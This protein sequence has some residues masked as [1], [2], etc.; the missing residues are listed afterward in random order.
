MEA[1]LEG[2]T[3]KYL[4]VSNLFADAFTDA[5]RS[6]CEGS[7]PQSKA[8]WEA[9]PQGK[10]PRKEKEENQMSDAK[11]EEPKGA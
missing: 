7:S 5:L 8:N 6:P 9:N 11:T 3:Q 2:K 1:P 10:N 4:G